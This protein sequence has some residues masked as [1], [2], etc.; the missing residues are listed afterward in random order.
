MKGTGKMKK[1]DKKK[2]VRINVTVGENIDNKIK[3]YADFMGMTK[4][5]LCAY[6]IAQMVMGYQNAQNSVDKAILNIASNEAKK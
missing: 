2:S 1:G 4:S 6:W 5:G 3:E